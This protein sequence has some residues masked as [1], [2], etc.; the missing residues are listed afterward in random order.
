MKVYTRTGDDGTTGLFGG[1]RVRKDHAR[2]TAYGTVDEAN[3]FVG[4]ARAEGS[5]DRLG[6]LLERIQAELFVVGA[7]LA[8]PSSARPSVPRISD[9]EIQAMERDID[10]LEA[11]LDPLKTFILPGGCKR[12]AA[13]HA[14][15][16][17]ARRAEREVVAAMESEPIDG[18]VA[19]YLNRLSDFL[20][21]AA[22]WANHSEDVPDTPWTP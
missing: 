19:V 5:K 13:L 9:D 7:D 8:T 15:R 10:A 22:R 21:V 2:I 20:F 4:M 14:A 17:I 6:K 1:D 18:R 16:T 3:A 12:A 11:D